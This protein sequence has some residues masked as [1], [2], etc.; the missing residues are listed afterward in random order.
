[1]EGEDKELVEATKTEDGNEYTKADYAYAPSDQPSEW[2]L[3]VAEYVNGKKQVTAMQ[4]GRAI[5]ALSPG[6][7]RGNRVQLPSDAVAGVKSKLRTLWKKLHADAEMSDMPAA[8]K[9]SQIPDSEFVLDNDFRAKVLRYFG[10]NEAV[11]SDQSYEQLHADLEMAVNAWPERPGEYMHVMWVFSDRLIACSWRLRGQDMESD[12]PMAMRR[13]IWEIPYQRSDETAITFGQPVEVREIELYEPVAESKKRQGDQRLTETIEQAITFTEATNGSRKIKAVGITADVV[14][15]NKRRYPRAVLAAAVAGLNSH[16]HESNGQGRLIATGEAEHP[17]DKTGRPNLLETVVKWEA[18]SLDSAGKVLLEGVILPTSKGKDILVLVENKVPVGVSMRG[19]GSFTIVE[20]SGESIQ[21]VTELTIKGFD[22]V[23][24]PSDPNGQVTESQ[25]GEPRTKDKR[26]MN[27]E[28]MLKAL[29][30]NPEM[31]DAIM[32]QFGFTDGNQLAEK[33]GVKS[34]E[35][36][37]RKLDEALKAQAELE[38]RKRQDAIDK[39][40]EEAAEDLPYDDDMNKLFVE[41]IR[42]RKPQTAEEVGKLF[43]SKRK[44]YDALAAMKKLNQMGKDK[45]KQGDGSFV[46]MMAPVFESQT[47]QPEFT[48]AAWMLNESMINSGAGTRRDLRSK[49]ETKSE[50]FTRK[51]LERFDQVYRPHLIAESRMFEEAEQTSDLNLP[52]TVMRTIVEQA[53]P[54]LIAANVFDFG[55]MQNSPERLYFE[56]YVGE[57]GAV[58][59]ITDEAV[60][61][62]HDDW[63]ALAHARIRPGTVVLTSSPAG[64]TFAEGTD[65]V[66]DYAQGRLMTLSTGSTTAAQALLIDYTYDAIR[67][68]EMQAIE[69]AKNALTFI[70]INAAADRLAV[71]ISSEAIVFSRS[72]LGYDAVGRTLSNLTRDIRRRIDSN[73]L[74]NALTA[75]LRQAN[76]SG[77]TWASGSD[78]LADFPKKIGM[79]RVKVENRFYMV[80]ALVM[81]KTNADLLSNWDGFTRQG[82]PNAVLN[83]AGFAGSVKGL[84]IFSSSEF[85]DGYVLAVN[86][87]LVMHRVFQPMAL[88][89]P[90]P[91]F[92]SDKLVGADQWYA[93]E[94]NSTETPVIEKGAYMVVS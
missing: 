29:E 81:S 54:E 58:V 23:A 64:T 86:R 66:I 46:S 25:K 32:K 33:L 47:G 61:G 40:I 56:S 63:V 6:G 79:A 19:F 37:Q 34:A 60:T 78:P 38:E 92:S 62:D 49:A 68:G 74:Y 82:F 90:F 50:I 73:I 11:R 51:V 69:R 26:P 42:G 93:E 14:N 55:V 71:Q 3:R 1:M 22:L 28:E 43:E 84:P 59:V 88:K 65:F 16:L 75:A 27:L 20:E 2:K 7:F 89:G 24:Q 5:A 10:L 67:K 31:K 36:V 4:V 52:Y 72:Q 18:A 85:S 57:T 87:E 94:Y 41:D 80:D 13:H 76:N 8:I 70:T 17:S 77:G 45:R 44:E 12:G 35:S 39:A 53:F 48:K 15:G 83:A 30:T 91:S 9:E 21:Q